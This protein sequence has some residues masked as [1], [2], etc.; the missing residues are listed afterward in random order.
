MHQVYS[1]DD[2]SKRS[3]HILMC[4]TSR[5]AE[6]QYMLNRLADA[7]IEGHQVLTENIGLTETTPTLVTTSKSAKAEDEKTGQSDDQ[8]TSTGGFTKQQQDNI[9]LLFAHK[10]HTNGPLSLHETRNFMSKS[11]NL[12]SLMSKISPTKIRRGRYQSSTRTRNP[13]KNSRVAEKVEWNINYKRK[14]CVEPQRRGGHR[15]RVLRLERIS[16]KGLYP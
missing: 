1:Q 16:E 7:A 4:H 3:A 9:N 8:E 15:E 5:T 6:Q 14:V 10:I 13:R 12:M 11:L 2:A